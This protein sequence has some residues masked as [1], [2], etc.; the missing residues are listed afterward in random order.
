MGLPHFDPERRV[1]ELPGGVSVEVRGLSRREFLA[2]PRVDEDDENPDLAELEVFM[3]AHG[4]D[5]PI[6]DARAWYD[7]APAAV[8]G[9]VIEAIYAVSG[10]SV[11]EGK[12]GGGA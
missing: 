4:T 3:L 7:T 8:V 2:R 10:V 6:E 11:D 9:P 1:V 12:G 5:T